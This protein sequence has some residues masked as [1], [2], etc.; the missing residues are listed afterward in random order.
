[1][2]G[3]LSSTDVAVI[4]GVLGPLLLMAIAAVIVVIIAII[5]VV[6]VRRHCSYCCF[7][8]NQVPDMLTEETGIAKHEVK[9]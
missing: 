2:A 1:M 8:V 7:S 5:F 9:H 4:G 3:G 6:R